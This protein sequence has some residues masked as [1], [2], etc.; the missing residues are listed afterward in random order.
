MKAMRLL[1]CRHAAPLSLLAAAWLLTQPRTGAAQSLS[2]DFAND[3]GPV[4]HP[5]SGWLYSWWHTRESPA[6]ANLE[7][8]PTS[9]RIGY[10]G[11]W[12]YEY[13]PMLD[14]GVT[15]IQVLLTDAFRNRAHGTVG[16]FSHDYTW[17]GKSYVQTVESTVQLVNQ[18]GWNHVAFDL[19]N[20]PDAFGIDGVGDWYADAWVPAFRKIR[21][22]RP[23]AEIVGPGFFSA[24][25]SHLRT[26]LAKARADNVVPDIVSQHLLDNQNADV[27]E[28]YN[29]QIR[30]MLTE[31]GL[32]QRPLSFNEYINPGHI[33]FVEDVVN[34]LAQGERVGI[35]SMMHSSWDDSGELPPWNSTGDAACFDGIMSIPA[36]RERACY[37]VYKFYGDMAG[38]N[39]H[40]SGS[41]AGWEGVASLESG[42]PVARVL[43]GGKN[44]GTSV[45]LALN[46]IPA[47]FG[48]SVNVRVERVNSNGNDL[49]AAPT[50]HAQADV[51]V[52]GGSASIPL[53][54]FPGRTALMVTIRPA[55]LPAR[56]SAPVFSP[57]R[58]AYWKTQDV[59]LSCGTSGATIRYTTDGSAPTGVSTPYTGPLRVSATTTIRA[60]GVKAGAPDSEVAN[61]TFT[62]RRADNGVYGE[63]YANTGLS[64]TPTLTR[65]DPKIDLNYG[66]N[67]LDASLPA[68][69]FSA[70]WTGRLRPYVSGAHVLETVTDDGVRLWIDNALVIDGWGGLGTRTASVNLTAGQ[71]HEL[72][73]EFYDGV[74]DSI[75]RLFWTPPGGS[76]A[77]IPTAR[78]FPPTAPSGANLL[79]GA[80]TVWKYLAPA[81]AG[82]APAAAWTDPGFNDA[83]WTSAPARIGYGGDGE[84]SAIDTTGGRPFT[85]YFR[86]TFSVSDP[87]AL[88]AYLD[89]AVV[90]DDGA[91]VYLNGAEIFRDNMPAGAVSY[92]TAALGGV[93]DSNESAPARFQVARARLL[94]GNNTLAIEIHQSDADSA[95][96]GFDCSLSNPTDNT[97]PVI[98]PIASRTV[99]RDRTAAPIG[100]S[101]SDGELFA[102]LITAS[103]TSSNTG[104][105]P[106]GSFTF[107]GYGRSRTLTLTPA[108][109]QTGS[110]NVTVTIGDGM[111]TAART[112]TVTVTD[113]P[114]NTAPT[115]SDVADRN[116]TAGTRSNEILF[117]VGD[118]QTEPG[119]LAVTATSSNTSLVPNASLF[120]N[121]TGDWRTIALTP[122]AGEGG[123][124]L[125]TLTVSDGSLTAT[126]TFTVTVGAAP[127]FL[128]YDFDNGTLQGWTD[129][130]A[131]NSNAGPRNW[132]PAPPAFPNATQGGAAAIG[133]NIVGGT[134]DSSHPTLWLRSPE[135]VLNGAGNLTAWL[136]GGTGSGSLAGATVASVPANSTSP[137]FQGV[138]LRNVGTGVFALSGSKVSSGDD[139]QQATFTQAQLAALDQGARY[140]LD[141]ID[142]GHGGWGWVAMD[143]VTI[144]GTL[145]GGGNTAPTIS[146]ITGRTI[147]RDAN[148]GAI[149]FTVGDAQ[150]D[151]GALT[152]GG[153]SSN[154]SLVPNA[155]I[156]FGGGGASRTV[157]VTPAAGRTGSATITVTVSDG[158]LTASDTFLL[159]V[160]SP[161]QALAAEDHFLAGGNP[162]AGEYATGNLGGQ[163]PTLTGWSTAWI[164][165]SNGDVQLSAIPLSYTGL[166]S[167]GGRISVPDGTRSGRVLS[168]PLTA[169]TAGTVYLSL[170][171]RMDGDDAARYRAFELHGGGFDD[172]AHR[173]LQLGQNAG[174]FGHINYGLR[175]LNNSALRAD[176]GAVD[177]EVNLFVIKFVLSAADNADSLTVWRNPGNLGG[178][179]P[180][181]GATLSG[182][183]L[184]FDRTSFAHFLQGAGFSA[185][186]LRIG[187]TWAAVTPTGSSADNRLF[188]EF[189]DG[190]FQGWTNIRT[191]NDYSP[192]YFEVAGGGDAQAGAFAIKQHLAD[193]WQ[194]F[195]D[196]AHQTLWVR[197]PAFT[198]NGAG[199]LS[200]WLMGGGVNPLATP[201]ANEAAVPASSVDTVSGGWHGVVL[202]QVTT[203]AF[204]LSGGRATDGFGWEQVVFTAARLAALD[205][206]AAYTL[207]LIDARNNAWSWFNCDTVSIPGVLAETPNTPPTISDVADRAIAAGGSTGPIPVTLGD[208]ETPAAALTLSGSSSS[209]WLVPNAGL[210]F[211][212]SGSNRTVTVT[213]LAGLRGR[214]TIT[215]TVSD[216]SRTARDTFV[217]TVGQPL[218]PLVYDFDDGTLQGWR[219]V[220]TD[221]TGRQLFAIQPPGV[222]SPNATPQAGTHFVGLHIPA[223]GGDP[224]YYQDS[225]HG[226]LWLRSPEFRLTGNGDLAAWLCGGHG[227]G[228]DATGKRVADV[229]ATAFDSPGAAP[230]P[231]FLGV[232]LRNVQSE[233]FVLAGT[234]SSPGNDW[235]QVVFTAVQLAALD[236]G[237]TYTLDL[238]D[239][240]QGG[241]GWVN[242]DSVTIPGWIARPGTVILLR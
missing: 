46:N 209:T 141:L 188:F 102:S 201:P 155:N 67:R 196:L 85:A 107:G 11:T 219:V 241:W 31:Y 98:G 235:Q 187:S 230:F 151:P 152:L 89:L 160:T 30:A 185:D 205:Q 211:G 12:D 149:G 179:E 236:P 51:A 135:F 52:S 111:A 233:M 69:N 144:P 8:K 153:S 198:L 58:G 37:W 100:F 225:T 226:T 48:S 60:I 59:S 44:A 191:N 129:L 172:G 112:F 186:E 138:A 50:L 162:A 49:T 239:V 77:I 10:W 92:D 218:P 182:F 133:Q 79:V 1:A 190:T 34:A 45:T 82:G 71:D 41:A 132:S 154:A 54:G 166:Q 234:K 3:R 88:S 29:N 200:F 227:Y 7:L 115:I 222:S 232:A 39:V 203:G 81:G 242:L 202:R 157:T 159:T 125:I 213:P 137:G 210:V 32:A 13:Q 68:D 20:E 33:S 5:G 224:L 231:S 24:N 73:M 164:K 27:V 110:A 229:P 207:D 197:S 206:G 214:A 120:L 143:S 99:Y 55:G 21:E 221:G 72:K 123:S 22:L 80:G 6:H 118:G 57:L 91:V 114:A 237:A 93:G 83:A 95:D 94:A 104:L 116:A 134:Q 18:R 131:A 208:A 86:K 184:T 145:P 17:Q 14:Q 87:A 127:T 163:N 113:P 165:A 139:W 70:R 238:L 228:A 175:V 78:L 148:T 122:A 101:V 25:L 2:V 19:I 75:A 65:G 74:G 26:F 216:G 181:G 192:Q 220:S 126:D 38:R 106:D 195:A 223:F 36:Q 147:D 121:G 177:A 4:T 168:A 90:R 136:R 35:Q 76:R 53:S 66:G 180:P 63:Y 169:A 28:S 212:G 199:D 193:T 15:H 62:I 158:E 117:N 16:G 178:V 171:L 167:S 84:V 170:L 124:A 109:G 23:Q 140:T 189:D 215:L 119:L 174:D 97:P 173:T 150:T 194:G 142:Q 47:A 103:A 96:F 217:L 204:V 130:T 183:N 61:G 146:D 40:T 56:V 105:I 9:W 64:G 156:V 43:L 161:G 240:R 42:T 108:A 128:T 176:L